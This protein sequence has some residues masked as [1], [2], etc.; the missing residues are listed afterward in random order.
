MPLPRTITSRHF[1]SSC[2][3][4]VSKETSITSPYES[5]M[6]SSAQFQRTP[7]ITACLPLVGIVPSL[8]G[9]TFYLLQKNVYCSILSTRASRHFPGEALPQLFCFQKRR[10]V[11]TRALYNFLLTLPLTPQTAHLASSSL[12]FN[13]RD[14]FCLPPD[15][16]DH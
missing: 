1:E 15:T 8:L 16:A 13:F 7:H 9:F 5:L 6:S 4:Q 11:L 14:L 2:C 12:V 3:F 10:G